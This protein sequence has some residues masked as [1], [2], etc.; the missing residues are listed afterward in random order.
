MFLKYSYSNSVQKFWLL[1]FYFNV[2][3]IQGGTQRDT[4][5]NAMSI[6]YSTGTIYILLASSC[7]VVLAI[8]LEALSLIVVGNVTDSDH[9]MQTCTRL[10][11]GDIDLVILIICHYDQY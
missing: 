10:N 7:Y 5:S 11:N 6:L 1:L 4:D 9:S 8:I 3:L 2:I